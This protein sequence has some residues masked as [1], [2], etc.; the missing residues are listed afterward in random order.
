MARLV[1]VKCPNCGANVRIDPDRDI[2]TCSY[3]KTSSFVQTPTRRLPDEARRD[4]P[5]VFDV[6]AYQNSLRGGM[7]ALWVYVFFAFAAGL[8]ALVAF[9]ASQA[10]RSAPAPP[11]QDDAL[12]LRRGEVSSSKTS[13]PAE[14]PAVPLG[15]TPRFST[16]RVVATGRLTP[17]VVE[18]GIRNHEN[19]F[20]LCHEQAEKRSTSAYGT[21]L[22]LFI[23]GR[24]GSVSKAT[25]G[26]SDVPSAVFVDC[27]TTVFA[28]MSFPK[29]ARGVVSVEYKLVIE[30]S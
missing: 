19:R 6:A 11:E 28:E 16:S 26:Y 30:P 12:A 13:E 15:R 2:A 21:L 23:I 29:P 3:C 9:L 10:R 17:A 25:V 18:K 20:R 4:N 7:T 27:M 14:V 1:P 8:V 5:M 22:M 24:D